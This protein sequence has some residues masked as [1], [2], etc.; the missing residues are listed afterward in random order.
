MEK[1]GPTC[2]GDVMLDFRMYELRDFGGCLD[3]I[4]AGHDSEFSEER[5]RW[6]H[7]RGPAGPSQ[8]AVCLR[9]DQ[10]VGMYSA[11]PKTVHFADA[12]FCGG[13][14]VDPVVHPSCRG[15]GV[16]GRLLEFGLA[17]FKGFD[18]FFNFANPASAVGFRRHGWQDIMPLEDRICQLGFRSPLSRAGLLW[19]LGRIV[20]PATGD[21]QT[22][23]LTTETF[24]ELLNSDSRFAGPDDQPPDGGVR[25]NVAYLTWRYLEHPLH[26]YIYFLAEN[27]TGGAAIAICRHE[28]AADRLTVV[29]LAGFNMTP[30]LAIWLPL[31]K[32]QFPRAT[33]TAWHSL[34]RQT[35]AGFIGNPGRR[36]RG[37]TFLVRECPGG[38]TP[39]GLFVGSNWFLTRGDLEIA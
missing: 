23:V 28:E 21:F 1:S 34:P 18:F 27:E 25:R 11:L 37:Q 16:F 39:S 17:N 3:L 14:D 35:L 22:R 38:E 31:W 5:F 33:V 9:G 36:G 30:H 7:E 24:G 8:I 2:I 6:L 26:R 32:T 4:R 12:N 13:R 29:D 15:Q 20:R 19:G 10:L